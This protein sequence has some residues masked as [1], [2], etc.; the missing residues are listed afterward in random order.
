MAVDG[1]I[2]AAT[3]LLQPSSLQEKH[4]R[5]AQ[6]AAQQL[7]AALDGAEEQDHELAAAL[8]SEPECD[9]NQVR[10]VVIIS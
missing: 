7:H 1:A 3:A 5:D 2:K 10:H 8:L 6:S 9:I 4:C